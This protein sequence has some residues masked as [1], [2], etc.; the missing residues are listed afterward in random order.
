M[1]PESEDKAATSTAL[2]LSPPAA[3]APLQESDTR[4]L[5][6]IDSAE[7]A[8][9]ESMAEK[10]AGE[11][12]TVEPSSPEFSKKVDA[13]HS[14]GSREIRDSASMSNRML[15]RPMHAMSSGLFD[16]KSDVAKGLIDLRKTIDDLDPSRQNLLSPKKL[17][18]IIPFGNKIRDYF[19][20]FQSAQTH[21]DHILQA[22]FRG[23]D[24]LRQDNGAVEQEKTNLRSIMQRLREYAYLAS[25]LD[26]SLV[27]KI[28]ETER[29]D[30]ERAKA[31]KED[32]LFYVRQKHQDLMTQLA[33]SAQGYLALELI[34]KNNQEL[35]KGVDRAT[36][37]TVSALRTAVMA[38]QALANQKLVLDQI[39]A[40][41]TTTG[42]MIESTSQML[43]DQSTRVHEQ[44]SSS[45][46][47]V[48]KLKNAFVNI[49][50]TIDAIDTY[51]MQA[52]DSFR[53]TIDAL[54]SEVQKAQKYLER[55][56]GTAA[57]ER[58]AGD[59]VLPSSLG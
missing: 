10:Y 14:M 41:N 53:Q 51:K 22:L 54:T 36:T 15:E 8:K 58:A 13:V 59:L 16:K 4:E 44:A 52:L 55:T 24:E 50:A 45:T 9:L 26:A 47:E 21:L 25:K 27:A 40:L 3:V 23:Q 48:D 5:V 35:I 17:L 28:A 33:V 39:T 12:V 37:T 18:G 31:L 42:N 7:K 30:P 29:A 57:A 34:R 2:V 56:D 32:V 46:I 1:A 6:P 20:K 38:A 49:Y 11:L 43:R 19:L